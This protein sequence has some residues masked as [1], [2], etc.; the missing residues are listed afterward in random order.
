MIIENHTDFLLTDLH[1]ATCGTTDELWVCLSCA[2]FAC[3]RLSSRHAEQHFKDTL[4][5]LV[6]QITTKYVHW[7]AHAYDACTVS[8]TCLHSYKCDDYVLADNK[9]F[10]LMLLRTE[11]S[12]IESMAEPSSSTRSGRSI[13]PPAAADEASCA[14]EGSFYRNMDLIESADRHR[15]HSLLRCVLN[16]WRS[17]VPPKQSAAT[18][19]S[20]AAPST[21]KATSA[22][23][24]KLDDVPG[25]T[26]LRN[27]GQ[28]CFLNAVLQTLLHSEI[29]RAGLASLGEQGLL[30]PQLSSASVELIRNT[31]TP[32]TRPRIQRQTT[33]QCHDTIETASQETKP[34]KRRG[35]DLDHADHEAPSLPPLAMCHNLESLFRVTWSG[36]WSVVTPH[37]ILSSIWQLI[38]A[39]RGFRQQDAQELLC[40][41]T[42]RMQSELGTLSRDLAPAAVPA[43]PMLLHT[44]WG[45]V[46]ST[47]TCGNCSAESRR[48]EAFCDL[49]LDMPIGSSVLM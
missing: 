43:I 18:T 29:L 30:D 32:K 19:S 25:S 24:S 1:T 11:L 47:V 35:A 42:E 26:G 27:L 6:M 33:V 39:F 13:R 45:Q 31:D 7:S 21:S 36:K 14:V 10:D 48:A 4:H 40:E 5:P 23:R 34:R 22:K 20:T 15:R 37:A 46:T 44:L 3:G 41:I 2:H 49:S 28:T 17:A 38:P 8:H 12:N 9:N 16:A